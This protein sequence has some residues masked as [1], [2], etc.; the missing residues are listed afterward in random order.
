MNLENWIMRLISLTVS[1]YILLILASHFCPELDRTIFFSNDE[2]TFL[3]F[4]W[5]LIYPRMR[6]VNL[7]ASRFLQFL[8]MQYFFYLDFTNS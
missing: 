1:K 4:Q 2:R 5:F 3:S 8:L 6:T 7:N